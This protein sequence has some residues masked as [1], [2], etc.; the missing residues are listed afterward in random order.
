MCESHARDSIKHPV[1]PRI[2]DE[3]F[4]EFQTL[5]DAMEKEI[6]TI[7]LPCISPLVPI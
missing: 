2:M 5:L 6:S 7:N 1:H 3:E 4:P